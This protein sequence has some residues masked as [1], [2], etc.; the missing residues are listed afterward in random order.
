[1]IRDKEID[2]LQSE[3]DN[4][5]SLYNRALETNSK[6]R[7]EIEELKKGNDSRLKELKAENGIL[8]RTIDVYVRKLAKMRATQ[9]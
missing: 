2:A 7:K 5:K 6:L 3:L 1:M 8:E 9:K 4:Y